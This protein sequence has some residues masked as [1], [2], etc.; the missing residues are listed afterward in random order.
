MNIWQH[1]NAQIVNGDTEAL[2]KTREDAEL[3]ASRLN[4]IFGAGSVKIVAA[5]MT[6]NDEMTIIPAFAVKSAK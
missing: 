5:T 4:E 1:M 6:A 3:F 2:F